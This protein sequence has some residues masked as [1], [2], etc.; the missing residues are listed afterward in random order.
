MRVTVS[1]SA[2]VDALASAGV[3]GARVGATNP[4]RLTV[5]EGEIRVSGRELAIRVEFPQDFPVNMPVVFVVNPESLGQVP[6]LLANGAICYHEGEGSVQSIW[7]PERVAAESV[8]LAIRTLE[9]SLAGEN[10]QSVFEEIEWW[11]SRQREPSR[12]W[13]SQFTPGPDIE[14]L[15]RAGA[16]IDNRHKRLNE[17]STTIERG[18]F[19]PMNPDPGRYRFSVPSLLR[20]SGIQRVLRENLESRVYKHLQG[21]LGRGANFRFVVLGIQRPSS[22]DHALIGIEFRGPLDPHPL[23]H[24]SMN[25]ESTLEPVLVHRLDRARMMERGGANPTLGNKTVAVV[26]CGAVG[27]YV[28]EALARTGVGN[29]IL[30]D[31][32]MITPENAYRHTLGWS[33]CAQYLPGFAFKVS[34]LHSTITLAMPSLISVTP[35]VNT[36]HDAIANGSLDLGGIDLMIVA[37]GNPTVSRLLN[38][39]LLAAH[40]PRALYTWLEPL[41]VGGHALL[42]GPCGA[43]GCYE[44]L[45]IDDAGRELLSP[46]TDFI[47]PNQPVLSR[48]AGCGTSYT[49]F[50]DLDARRTA[51]SAVRLAVRALEGKEPEARLRSWRGD[52]DA[53]RAKG[54]VMT[55]RHTSRH[56]QLE[57]EETRFALSDCGVCGL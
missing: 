27:G 19:I 53:A 9:R 26:G 28:A 42:T 40:G 5:I 4:L 25:D 1:I 30:V 46:R 47:A 52:A 23:K 11:W 24:G 48:V 3:V 50:A 16:L 39:D 33:F 35:L 18:L 49:P 31:N 54:L 17:L 13:A 57:A 21:R 51:E 41:G 29:L 6:H 38:L 56:E 15:Y 2:L 34:L 45:C 37:V 7:Y 43:P 10:A 14:V 12:S 44:C 20:R 22:S 8:Q 36:V 32:D 55:E